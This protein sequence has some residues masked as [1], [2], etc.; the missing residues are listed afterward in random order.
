MARPMLDIT[1]Y[2]G[3]TSGADGKRVDVMFS[4]NNYFKFALNIRN[5]GGGDYILHQYNVRLCV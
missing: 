3:G 5:K 1:A 2:Y 4:N